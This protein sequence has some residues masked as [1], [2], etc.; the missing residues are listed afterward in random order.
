MTTQQDRPVHDT[1]AA[2]DIDSIEPG[3]CTTFSK[4]VSES[5]IYGFS[6]I[7]GDFAGNHVNEQYMSTTPYGRRIAQGMLVL[8][9]TT[10]AS[11]AFGER[12]RLHAVSAG[13][14]G[15]RFIKPVFIGDTI[16]V[17]Y[18]LDRVDHAKRRLHNKVTVTNQDGEVVL[19]GEHLLAIMPDQLKGGA[20][21]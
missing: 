20:A 16:N 18:A 2:S 4:T 13:Y 14:E 9:Y 7:T 10:A 1:F 5:D 3:A 17:E 12:Y 19:V 21:Q 6:G 11:S 8:G 15:V